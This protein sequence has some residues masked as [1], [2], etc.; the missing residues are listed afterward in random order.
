LFL[1]ARGYVGSNYDYNVNSMNEVTGSE[2]KELTHL[3]GMTIE[4]KILSDGS[5]FDG[6]TASPI[7]RNPS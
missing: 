6:G 1:A 7:Q 2:I 5:S 3:K 4:L